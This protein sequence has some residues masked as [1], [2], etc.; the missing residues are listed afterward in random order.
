MRDLGE[1]EAQVMR[2]L[3]DWDC[4][5]TVREVL[6]DLT[7]D[8]KLA[9]TTVMTVLDN[10]HKK[11]YVSRE[12]VGRAY[13]YRSVKTREEHTADL[14]SVALERSHDRPASLLLFVERLDPEEQ[15][16]LRAS[17]AAMVEQPSRG[18]RARP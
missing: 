14:I 6:A 18:R 9:Y 1:L 15:A 10:L 16:A 12:V 5:C 7:A 17:L 13:H 11:G 2:R 3:W 4:A 8:R